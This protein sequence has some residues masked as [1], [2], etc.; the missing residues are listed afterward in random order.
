MYSGSEE[1]AT[2]EVCAISS[3]ELARTVNVGIEAGTVG[4]AQSQ[5]IFY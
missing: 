2:V 3:A 4:S 1:A 5:G